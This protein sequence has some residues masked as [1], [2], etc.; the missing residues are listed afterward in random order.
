MAK[1]SR[2]P[3]LPTSK[4]KAPVAGKKEKSA[5]KPVSKRIKPKVSAKMPGASSKLKPAK[6][7]AK[8][9]QTSAKVKPFTPNKPA[10]L[11][12]KST[13]ESKVIPR[14]PAPIT[15]QKSTLI[16]QYEVAVK[17]VYSQEFAKAKESLEKII[18]SA[19]QDKDIAERA[20]SLLR[21]CDQKLSGSGGSPRSMDDLYNM[22]VALMNQGKLGEAREQFQKALKLNAR[23][24]YVLYALAATHSRSGNLEEALDTLKAAISLKPGNRFLARNDSDFDP[25]AHDFRFLAL[26]A[27]DHL[28]GSS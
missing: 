12:S 17:L 25:L 28:A 14:K 7:A 13:A 20:K 21:I 3:K 15:S 1:T 10:N 22:G 6:S 11:A 16:R 5:T 26:V 8:V 27:P 18:Q 23:C 9:Q 24:E 4:K 19:L 2:T